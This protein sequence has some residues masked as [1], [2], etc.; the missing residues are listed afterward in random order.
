MHNYIN[1]QT[2]ESVIWSAVERFSVQAIQFVLTIILA[3]LISPAEFGLIAMLGIFMQV[4]QSFVD[5]GFSNALIQKRNRTE[6]DF[7]TVFYFN[8]IISIVTYIALY[9]AASHI[10]QFYDEPILE[11]ICKWI[12]VNLIIQGVAVVQVAKLTIDLNFKTQAKSSLVAITI[13]GILGV[14]LAYNGYGVWALVIQSLLNTFINTLLLFF[15]TK[16][17]PTHLNFL[18]YLLNLCL[19]LDLNF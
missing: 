5:S 17:K 14:Y 2:V 3:R 19:H 18:Y 13:S 11:N 6:A 15:F 9:I 4:A 16:W 10:A 1:N 12:G 8:C 7:S